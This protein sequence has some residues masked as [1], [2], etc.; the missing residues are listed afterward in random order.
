LLEYA[1]AHGRSQPTYRTVRAEGPSHD[2]TFT[3][4][5]LLDG[6]PRGQGVAGSKKEAEQQAAREALDRVQAKET[7]S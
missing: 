2:R 3:V 5:A 6:T 7:T 4:E 1:Q